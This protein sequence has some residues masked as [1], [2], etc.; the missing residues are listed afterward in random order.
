[1]YFKNVYRQLVFIAALLLAVPAMSQVRV[2]L[3]LG[4]LQEN[5]SST[6]LSS[7]GRTF[8]DGYVN[9]AFKK[10]FPL[11]LALGYLYV[12][13]VENYSD[14]TYT[15]LTSA[16]PYL[17]ISYQFLKKSFT[18]FIVTGAYSPYAKL[19]V[20]E[21]AGQESW[22]GNTM[23]A[24]FSASFNLSERSKINVGLY[25]ISESFSSRTSGNLTTKSAFNQSYLMPSLGVAFAF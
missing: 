21:T 24:K 17:G 18:S 19:D 12:N 6:Q 1:M 15:K 3:D 4:T 23:I 8:Y 20:S 10:E 14:S 16:N 25:Y 2:G 22:N 9:V 11:Y 7:L 5:R 13:S